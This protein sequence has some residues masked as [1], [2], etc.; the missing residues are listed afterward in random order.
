MKN[1]PAGPI[2]VTIMVHP[3]Q[4]WS[5]VMNSALMSLPKFNVYYKFLAHMFLLYTND[6][7]YTL[8]Q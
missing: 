4:K 7:A 1:G 8:N 2:M 5:G 6:L 3:D